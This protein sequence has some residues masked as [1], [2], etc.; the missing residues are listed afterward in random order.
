LIE[1]AIAQQAQAINYFLDDFI[2]THF[3]LSVKEFLA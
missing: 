1:I 3:T 2:V